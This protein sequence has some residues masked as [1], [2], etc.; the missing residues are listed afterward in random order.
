MMIGPAA[1]IERLNKHMPRLFSIVGRCV[2]RNGDIAE[3]AQDRLAFS[4]YPG[5]SSLSCDCYDGILLLRGRVSSY[6]QKQMAQ[7]AVR[8]VA[9]IRE[10]VNLVQVIVP[11]GS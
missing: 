9:G 6:Y 8:H 5:L 4:A 11:N 1:Q 2:S 10:L 7:E 3:A